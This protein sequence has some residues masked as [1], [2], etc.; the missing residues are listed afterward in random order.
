MAKHKAKQLSREERERRALNQLRGTTKPSVRVR[1]LRQELSAPEIVRLVKAIDSNS[2]FRDKILPPAFPRTLKDLERN[3]PYTA[4]LGLERDLAWATARCLTDREAL[5][6]F[7]R[8]LVR[9]EKA[10]LAANYEGAARELDD[11]EER[12]GQSLWLIQAKVFLLQNRFGYD[13][14]MEF[15]KQVQQQTTGAAG[16]V[17]HFA[18]RRNEPALGFDN[19]RQYVQELITDKDGSRFNS[20]LRF[21][22]MPG[23]NLELNFLGA[24]LGE[25]ISGSVVD[26][27]ILARVILASQFA[28][29]T[30]IRSDVDYLAEKLRT[31]TDDPFLCS[32]LGDLPS[33][34]S[35][36]FTAVAHATELLLQKQYD[37]SAKVAADILRGDPGNADAALLALLSLRNAEQITELHLPKPISLF[38]QHA[39]EMLAS[40][41]RL[42]TAASELTKWASNAHG[43]RIGFFAAALPDLDMRAVNPLTRIRAAMASESSHPIWLRWTTDSQP[44][45]DRQFLLSQELPWETGTVSHMQS[46]SA[47]TVTPPPMSDEALIATSA[48]VLSRKQGRDLIDALSAGLATLRQPYYRRIATGQ[49]SDAYLQSDQLDNAVRLVAQ[50]VVAE[51]TWQYSLPIVTLGEELSRDETRAH[52]LESAIVLERYQQ[53]HNPHADVKVVF[54]VREV[55]ASEGTNAP[56]KLAMDN[57]KIPILVR[58]L[59]DVCTEA[60]L[61]RTGF[62][63]SSDSVA[64]ERLNVCERL[65][66]LDPQSTNLYQNE[67]KDITKRR[68]I[69]QRLKEVERSKIFIDISRLRK[70]STEQLGEAF[71]RYKALRAGK[72]LPRPTIT[73]APSDADGPPVVVM[74]LGRDD[75]STQFQSMINQIRDS[76]VGNPDYGLDKYLSVRIRHGTFTSHLRSP[77]EEA[78]LVTSKE[79]GGRGYRLNEH[80]AKEAFPF[81]P[82]KRRE[83]AERLTQFSEV[84]DSLVERTKSL[85][86]ISKEHG[87]G[88]LFRFRI[89]PTTIAGLETQFSK[90]EADIALF[91]DKVVSIC[92]E[93]LDAALVKV[94]NVI[95][96]DFKSSASSL[97]EQLAEDLNA[98]GLPTG[99]LVNAVR[100]TNESLRVETDRV[101][102]WF[103]RSASTISD[104][105]SIEEV[106]EVVKQMAKRTSRT[107]TL[108][109]DFRAVEQLRFSGASM[110]SMIDA[111]SIVVDNAIKHSGLDPAKASLKAWRDRA[112]T[113]LLFENNLGNKIDRENVRQRFES[114]RQAIRA[115]EGRSAVTKEGGTGLHKLSG[116]LTNDFGT[117]SECSFDIN[118]AGVVSVHIVIADEPVA[119]Q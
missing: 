74:T 109:T 5:R 78:R 68:V 12:L 117:N 77:V 24:A 82:V 35:P 88:G 112:G 30:S 110:F 23:V 17:A 2:F 54:E 107:F 52:N 38:L 64:E 20:F 28:E 102:D 9:F 71:V 7:A 55:I 26:C 36:H 4:S 50:A 43:T 40:G 116:I 1:Q 15:V 29:S 10:M 13:A 118:D 119:L 46:L 101:R 53:L 62:F 42:G 41:D 96:V 31:A 87:E 63:R 89:S 72:A 8:H 6:S 69:A 19:Y 83:L 14:Q 49:L 65:L 11:A 98:M 106:V 97:L 25:C 57:V 58:F 48:V 92:D 99:A 104:P 80:W 114:I 67:I 18:S 93:L 113:H 33:Q 21:Q 84:Y 79:V 47:A 115:G 86:T 44:H 37:A 95:E 75:M 105:F 111:L 81:D 16:I 66:Q 32:L 56:S 34:T 60:V 103:R 3:Q 90:P 22:A 59:R 76:Y 39:R 61:E 73:L 108:Q 70:E 27:F 51:P 91:V 100:Q 94:R 45:F 85:L